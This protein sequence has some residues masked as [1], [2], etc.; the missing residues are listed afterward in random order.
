MNTKKQL[1]S[2]I[3]TDFQLEGAS[4]KKTSS[5]R[6]KVSKSLKSGK[7]GRV[8]GKIEKISEKNGKV[9]ATC[10]IPLGKEFSKKGFKILFPKDGLNVYPSQDLIAQVK[11]LD[12]KKKNVYSKK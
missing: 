1:N 7:P 8:W 6:R 9:Y 4:P 11:K 3:I 12:Q 5:F 10:S 2:I